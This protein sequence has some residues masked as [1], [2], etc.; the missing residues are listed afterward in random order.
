MPTKKRRDTSRN[1][2]SSVLAMAGLLP[3]GLF[4]VAAASD[5]ESSDS[6]AQAVH[7]VEISH[8]AAAAYND[9]TVGMVTPVLRNPT[10][11]RSQQTVAADAIAQQ[12]GEELLEGLNLAVGEAL[13]NVTVNLGAFAIPAVMLEAYKKAAAQMEALRPSC[14]I[15]WT[16]LAGIGHVES[17]HASGGAVDVNGRTLRPILGPRLDGTTP[18]TAV[19]RDTDGGELDGDSQFDRAVGPMQFIPSTWR[20]YATDGNGDGQADPH[21][22]YDA[23][24]AAA[25]YLCDAGG[26]LTVAGNQERA[27][28]RYNASRSYLNNVRN[29]ATAYAT[30]VLPTPTDLPPAGA[31][32]WEL[33]DPSAE[34]AADP[35]SSLID[36][37]RRGEDG[38]LDDRDEDE[39]R[40]EDRPRNPLDELAEMLPPPPQ[41][42]CVI[43]CAPQPGPDQGD[44]GAPPPPPPSLPEIPGLPDL[45]LPF[46]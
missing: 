9:S 21:N 31:L 30:G 24:V 27:I 10:V 16:L 22:V 25:K 12:A 13:N 32:P 37:L 45:R 15:S 36:E 42:P 3:A 33:P 19:I 23:T 41:V 26:D 29:W 44:E 14:G 6:A 4:G 11:L 46:P 43:F 2:R 18:N 17:G 1:R 35:M 34:A 5:L 39:A 8:A 20:M 28:L 38:E 7:E 40:D